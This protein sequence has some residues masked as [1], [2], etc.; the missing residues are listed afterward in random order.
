MSAGFEAKPFKK[1]S[2]QVYE[3]KFKKKFRVAGELGY[4]GDENLSNSKVFYTVLGVRYR[5]NKFI[6]AGL[7][8]RYNF[9][10]KYTNNSHRIDAQLNIAVD[11]GHL[12][13]GYRMVMQHEF[14]LV[15]DYRDILRNRLSVGYRTKKFPLDPYISMETFHVFHYTGDQLIGLRYELGAEVELAKDHS[16]DVSVRHDREQN[17]PGLKYR[18]IFS[19]AYEF[20]WKR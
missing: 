5:F 17:M 18:W 14:L 1:K 15:F 16:I 2:G 19:V 3:Y 9:R 7:E 4:R 10:D 13:F 12:S 11:V 20:K 6:R 8:H